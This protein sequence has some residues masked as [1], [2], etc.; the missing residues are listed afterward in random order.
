MR[1]RA[2]LASLGV[3]LGLAGCS[4]KSNEGEQSQKQTKSE[5]T[6]SYI[7]SES[8]GRPT[9]KS[10]ADPHTTETPRKTDTAVETDTNTSTSRSSVVH[11]RI[12][13][14][15]HFRNT[16]HAEPA[17]TGKQWLVVRYTAYNAGNESVSLAPADFTWRGKNSQDVDG[18]S[19]PVPYTYLGRREYTESDTIHSNQSTTRSMSFAVPKSATSQQLDL[20][21]TSPATIKM[22]PTTL[23]DQRRCHLDEFDCKG[24]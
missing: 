1:R 23:P 20:D 14:E 21:F 5:Q 19:G 6:K 24:L 10:R 7:D 9:N 4:V 22:Y 18:P 11:L 16:L 15:T 2:L 8:D 12:G 17:P 13:F 3:T